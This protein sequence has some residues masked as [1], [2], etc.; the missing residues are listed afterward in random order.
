MIIFTFGSPE[1]TSQN[2]RLPPNTYNLAGLM[3]FVLPTSTSTTSDN[4]DG[5]PR[6]HYNASMGIRPP[7][8]GGV[9]NPLLPPT[10]PSSSY[11]APPSYPVPPPPG[12]AS[13][14][15]PQLELHD[16]TSYPTGGASAQLP[17]PHNP[18][19]LELDFSLALRLFENGCIAFCCTFLYA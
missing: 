4:S 12:G 13:P 8:D 5:R 14:S 2:I 10:N 19:D 6:Y 3:E 15:A 11:F 18:A 16:M 1:P 7:Q 9:R 17:P